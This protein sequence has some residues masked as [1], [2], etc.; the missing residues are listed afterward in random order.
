MG[1][2]DDG[3]S[4]DFIEIEKFTCKMY[5][6]K[7]FRKIA[8]VITEIFMEKYK[9]KIDGNKISCAKKLGVAIM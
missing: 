3:Q 9:P 8:D 2:L 7:N 5:G 1:E 4:N 6:K